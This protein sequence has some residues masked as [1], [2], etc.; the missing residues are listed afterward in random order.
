MNAQN[1]AGHESAEQNAGEPAAQRPQEAAND[2]EH[3][4]QAET[5][6]ARR[7][8]PAA[9]APSDQRPV[10]ITFAQYEELKTL[11]RERDEYLR[12]LQRAVADCQNLRKRI[13]RMRETINRDA[14]KR[15]ALQVV[16]LADGLAR[17]LEIVD[18]TQGAENIAE[19]LR[20]LEKEFYSILDN[21]GVQPIEAV[22]KPFDP[23]YHEALLQEA[24]EGAEPNTVVRELKRGFVMGEEIIRPTAVAVAAPQQDT[25]EADQGT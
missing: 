6:E 2:E 7:E 12:R 22:G 24:V 4:S 10:T 8:R 25:Q 16:S 15:V 13:D 9:A 14:I 11:A 19:G 18:Q 20:L 5:A 23:H 17:A 21:F 1:E 3:T